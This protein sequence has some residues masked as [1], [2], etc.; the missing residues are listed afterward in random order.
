M[1]RITQ[2]PSAPQTVPRKPRPDDPIP[3][4]PPAFFVR[5]LKR[6]GSLGVVGSNSR[7]LK[8]V[9]SGNITGAGPLKRQKL[10]ANGSVADLGSG[11]RLG[12]LDVAPGNL[13]FKVPELPLKQGKVKGKGKEKDVFGDVS[14]FARVGKGKQKADEGSMVV[15][16]EAAFE[17]ANKNVSFGVASL[18]SLPQLNQPTGH[19][20]I[21][22]RIPWENQGSNRRNAVY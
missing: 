12:V 19:Q 13:V 16:D 18:A 9:A 17:K 7:E 2:R 20:A 8:R 1:G 3:R 4:K 22:N 11:V 14:E 21:D 6:T 5:D 10:A 15:V